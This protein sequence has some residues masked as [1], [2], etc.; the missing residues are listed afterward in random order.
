MSNSNS[1]GR[2][3]P[4]ETIPD[5]AS[6]PQETSDDVTV[7]IEEAE[8]EIQGASLRARWKQLGKEIGAIRI[9][10]QRNTGKS[11]E[12]HRLLDNLKERYQ[13]AMDELNAFESRSAA[14]WEEF[15]KDM[16]QRHLD[17][18]DELRRVTSLVRQ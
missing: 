15:R 1:R 18:K 6:Q 10:D 7:E 11:A 16:E 17:L 5:S 13:L 4:S 9:L 2:P 3:K 8:L 14:E 12:H